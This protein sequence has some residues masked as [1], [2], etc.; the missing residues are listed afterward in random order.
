M[1][2][3]GPTRLWWRPGVEEHLRSYVYLLSDP[4]THPP[5][6]FYVGKGTGSRCFAHIVEA[7]RTRQ[8]GTAEYPK[9]ATIRAIEADGLPVQIELLRHGLDEGA[10][11]D[12]ESTVIDLFPDLTNRVKGHH[13]DARGRA[14][15]VAINARYAAEPATFGPEDKVVL[16]RVTW[17]FPRPFDWDALY[18]ATRGYWIVGERRRHVGTPSAPDYALAV[19]E[20]VVRAVYRIDEWFR[21]PDDEIAKGRGGLRR[22]GFSGRLAR[23]L[24]DRYL[25]RDVTAWLPRGAQTPLRYI[26]C[27][28]GRPVST[29]RIQPGRSG[30]IATARPTR[31][32]VADTGTS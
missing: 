9:L 3:G 26:N 11:F 8:A 23:D 20:G 5:T 18:E 12:I 29:T 27:D 10:A 32:N 13:S 2:L 16:I 31:G 6:P 7:R 21:T 15:A 14:A 4:R 22:W 24:E 1:E 25:G 17:R 19:H 30:R 28:Y